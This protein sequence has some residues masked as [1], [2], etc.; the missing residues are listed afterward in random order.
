MLSEP[1]GVKSRPIRPTRLVPAL[2]T[3]IALVVVF[4]QPGRVAVKT[5]LLLPDMF[6]GSP[7]RPLTWLTGPPRFEEVAFDYP[8]GHIDADIY[9]PADDG[10]HG[11]L[12]LLLGAVGFPRR[13]PTL[14]RFAD[15]LS[16]AG[17]VVLIPESSNLQQ[18]E[19]TAGDVD[20]LLQA[21][22]NLRDRPEVDPTRIGFL[23]FSVGGSIALLTATDKRG[24]GQVAFVNA[25][26]S[27]ADAVDLLVDVASRSIVVDGQVVPWQPADLTIWV[28]SKQV[29]APLA[30]EHDRQLL[31]RV[32]LDKQPVDPTELTTLSAN[33]RLVLELLQ[34][35]PRERVAAILAALPP[36]IAAKLASISPSQHLGA[37]QAHLYL[38]HDHA[39]SYIPFTESRQL[40]TQ[41][42]PGTLQ[43]YQEFDLFAHVMPDRPL[44]GPIF[45]R[46]LLKLY[47]QAW[48]MCLEFL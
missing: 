8:A 27:Y 9:L 15:G 42:P 25:F 16:R 38:M 41:A 40:A 24:R 46:E 28:F 39:D 32:F 48:R 12:I 36:A 7:A 26:G 45:A 3:L 17:A 44:E 37:L 34:G 14:V 47:Y 22:A 2:L 21:V 1:A 31:S 18:G 35:A 10:P 13:E 43:A 33:G 19:I 11:A 4:S 30:D 5:L 6:P 20:G 29:I 23:G